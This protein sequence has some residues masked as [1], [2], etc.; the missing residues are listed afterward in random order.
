MNKILFKLFG[1]DARWLQKRLVKSVVDFNKT[2]PSEFTCPVVRTNWGIA[3]ASWYTDKMEKY[4]GRCDAIPFH[5][6]ALVNRTN[7]SFERA[8]F[9]QQLAKDYQ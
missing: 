6:L 1:N 3:G 4:T 5:S 2:Y 7:S 9:L 8:K